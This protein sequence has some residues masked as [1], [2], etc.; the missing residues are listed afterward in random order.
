M[1]FKVISLLTIYFFY[2]SELY[3][4]TL[5]LLLLLLKIRVN[6]NRTLINVFKIT[7]FLFTNDRLYPSNPNMHR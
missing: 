4:L 5:P 3:Y 6:M 7:L 2:F 1:K